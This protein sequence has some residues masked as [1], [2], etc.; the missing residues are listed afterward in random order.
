MKS[1]WTWLNN[2]LISKWPTN[3]LF[4]QHKSYMNHLLKQ[5]DNTNT[6]ELVYPDNQSHQPKSLFRFPSLS[7]SI[8]FLSGIVVS[9]KNT[10]RIYRHGFQQSRFRWN[11][12]EINP[13]LGDEGRAKAQPGLGIVTARVSNLHPVPSESHLSLI[14]NKKRITSF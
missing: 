9:S 3:I 8:P 2:K 10:I 14:Q 1:I 13:T 7:L 5:P 12:R 11:P 4:S 6:I